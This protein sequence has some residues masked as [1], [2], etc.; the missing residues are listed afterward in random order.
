[1]KKERVT[2]PR[3]CAIVRY[4][5]EN[6]IIPVNPDDPECFACRQA[7]KR[8]RALER[9]HM[10]AVSALGSFEADNFV[11]LC[12]GCHQEAPMTTD[13]HTLIAWVMDHESWADS[14]S[15]EV[16]AAVEIAK[17]ENLSFHEFT[18]QDRRRFGQFLRLRKFD[19]HPR[20]TRAQ[21]LKNLALMVRE[22]IL[23]K[24]FFPDAPQSSAHQAS[25]I[26]PR[27]RPTTSVPEMGLATPEVRSAAVTSPP[28]SDSGAKADVTADETEDASEDAIESTLLA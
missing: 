16:M 13:R 17:P 5:A 10:V 21:R 20:A 14:F 3:H 25:A 6:S 18:E 2:P 22:Y 27:M 8:W 28:E 9:C 4:W 19:C 26:P 23:L 15:R 1:M 7:V 11:L 24:R 12:Q